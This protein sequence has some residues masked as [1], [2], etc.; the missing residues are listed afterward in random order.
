MNGPGKILRGLVRPFF[1]Y[2]AC[3]SRKYEMDC[4]CER[5]RG[6]SRVRREEG[7]DVCDGLGL[8]VGGQ[9]VEEDAAVA[10]ALM[11]G[12]SSISTPRSLSERMRRPKPC[13][14]VMTALG[15]W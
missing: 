13:L 9:R 1:L 11:R 5:G 10:L 2:A 14:S 6:A 12:S 15:T 8:A 3:L 7:F 4:P